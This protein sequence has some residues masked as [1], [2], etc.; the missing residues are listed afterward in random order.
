[1][2]ITD[3]VG[4]PIKGIASFDYKDHKVVFDT[5]NGTSNPNIMIQNSG[6]KMTKVTC[7]EEAIL[8]I[9]GSLTSPE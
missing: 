9:E 5:L 7:I 8:I 1:M 4:I 6:G 2:R 3:D